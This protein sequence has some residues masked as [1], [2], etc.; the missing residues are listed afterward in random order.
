MDAKRQYER[1]KPLRAQNLIAQADLDTAAGQRRRGRGG[2]GRRRRGTWRRR[3]PSSPRPRSTSSYTTIVS[4]ID[5]VVISRSVDVGQTVAAS[6]QA[7]TLFTI[8]E[9]LRKMQVDTSVAEADVGK[10]GRRDGGHVHG[11]R[12]PRRAL[13]GQHPADP[14]RA[15][16]AAERRHLRRGHRRRQPR[17]QAPAGHDRQRHLRLRRARRTCCGSR[18]PRCASGRRPSCWPRSA[19]RRS[20]GRGGATSRRGRRQAAAKALDGRARSG[21]AHRA[22]AGEQPHGAG[23]CAAALP[24]PVQIARRRRRRQR[25]SPRSTRRARA[26]PRRRHRW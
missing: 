11:R 5:G 1:D 20:G 13:Q 14:Q 19:G 16:D 26:R 23:C 9:D 21:A 6:L 24:E 25:W 2:G 3:G 22:P 4:P 10:L 7:P 12:L 15:A 17:P 8:A 18:T